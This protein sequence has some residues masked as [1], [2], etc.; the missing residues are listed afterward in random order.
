MEAKSKRVQIWRDDRSDD[1][2]VTADVSPLATVG[3]TLKLV[4][5]QVNV[6]VWFW[7]L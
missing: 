2:A 3:S 4:L 5:V 1:A 6:F 7:H